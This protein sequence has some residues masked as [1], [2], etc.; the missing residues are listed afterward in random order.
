M[1]PAD[2]R[3]QMPPENFCPL[4]PS[5]ETPDNAP[6]VDTRNHL[7]FWDELE[8]HKVTPTIRLISMLFLAKI[9]MAPNDILLAT[10]FL[11]DSYNS[12]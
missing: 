2:H 10:S 7:T 3:F 9:K 8:C 12:P 1:S 11:C 4:D 5:A 6:W